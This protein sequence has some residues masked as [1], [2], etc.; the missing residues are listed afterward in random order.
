MAEQSKA[1]NLGKSLPQQGFSSPIEGA[2]LN[3]TLVRLF[4]VLDDK[5]CW[6]VTT[7]ELE[8]PSGKSAVLQVLGGKPT[9]HK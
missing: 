8:V 3:L 7:G 6:L 4:P 5:S 9:S 1:C 2:S